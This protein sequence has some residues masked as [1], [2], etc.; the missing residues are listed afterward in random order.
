MLEVNYTAVV[1][2]L[3]QGETLYLGSDMSVVQL[4]V[5]TCHAY[6]KVDLCVYDPYCGWDAKTNECVQAT[7]GRR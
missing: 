7:G 6:T 3:S 4:S 2:A 5:V 1:C